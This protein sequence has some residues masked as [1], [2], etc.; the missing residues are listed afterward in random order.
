M[1]TTAGKP[2]APRAADVERWIGEIKF[3]EETG[4]HYGGGALASS[5]KAAAYARR[6]LHSYGLGPDGKPLDAKAKAAGAAPGD[7]PIARWRTSLGGG[8]EVRFEGVTIALAWYSARPAAG[9]RGASPGGFGAVVR[10]GG[11]DS[12]LR[13]EQR[14]DGI[15]EARARAIDFAREALR[16]ELDRIKRAI[17]GLDRIGDELP[18]PPAAPRRRGRR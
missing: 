18:A 3:H 14:V 4:C 16:D 10:L 5:T 13:D 15:V 1:G 12:N 11:I 2:K 6:K 17:D 7:E 8:D 9:G